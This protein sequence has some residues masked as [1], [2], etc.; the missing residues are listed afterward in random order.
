ML[1]FVHGIKHRVK[2]GARQLRVASSNIG[3]HQGDPVA[4]VVGA[5]EPRDGK[6]GGEQAHHPC[7]PAMQLRRLGFCA[8]VTALTKKRLPPAV[9]TRSALPGEYPPGWEWAATTG[10]PTRSSTAER[11]ESG[12]SVQP[13]RERRSGALGASLASAGRFGARSLMK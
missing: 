9:T 7:F 5:Y 2:V 10:L 13:M 3:E 4:V 11:T 6:P 12:R 1:R 8:L